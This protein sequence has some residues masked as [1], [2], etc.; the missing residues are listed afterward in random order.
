M[1]A[2]D[3][4]YS[5]IR[6]SIVPGTYAP[7]ARLGEAEIAELTETSRPPVAAREG[8]RVFDA[9]AHSLPHH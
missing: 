9:S 1:R 5:R 2:V 4:V 6:D 8:I 3:R 7:G